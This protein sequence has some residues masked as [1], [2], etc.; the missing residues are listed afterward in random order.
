[1]LTLPH[2]AL[3]SRCTICTL[4]PGSTMVM[5]TGHLF[6]TASASAPAITFL[7]CSRVSAA[8]YSGGGCWAAATPTVTTTTAMRATDDRSVRIIVLLLEWV[9]GSR[10]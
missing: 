1:M 8:P 4:P 9:G 6:F 2:W 10:P 3:S 7:A 5:T